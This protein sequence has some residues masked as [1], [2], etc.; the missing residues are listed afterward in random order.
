M[1][2]HLSADHLSAQKV[3]DLVLQEREKALSPREWRH[4]IAGY[5]YG[6]K[7]TDE[8]LVITALP[9]HTELCALPAHVAA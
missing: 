7:D 4:R 1:T 3:V 5:G 6:L 2:M 9:K 8:G